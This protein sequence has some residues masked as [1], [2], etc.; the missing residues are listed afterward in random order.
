MKLLV[1]EDTPV[2]RRVLETTLTKWGYELLVAKDGQEAWDILQTEPD[3]G[4]AVLDWMMPGIDGIDVCRMIRARQDA[5]YVYVIMLTAKS[6]QQDIVEGLNAGADD[7]V[8]KPFNCSEL[9]VRIRAGERIVRLQRGFANKVE[10]LEE[11]LQH[12][13]DLRGLLPICMDCRRV[14][15]DND[16]W[17]QLESYLVSRMG[18]DLSHSL[19]PECLE[20]RLG[21]A[22]ESEEAP[23]MAETA[24]MKPSM[25]AMERLSLED[26]PLLQQLDNLLVDESG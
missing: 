2:S 5:P 15:D 14:R 11:A 13:N 23:P 21:D 22:D 6:Q 17:Q 9:R 3:I 7:Y 26:D 24:A 25:A 8:T 4:V 12:V 20:R 1:A 19:C 18:T 16:Y 10:E